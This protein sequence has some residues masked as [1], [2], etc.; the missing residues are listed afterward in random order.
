MT[1]LPSTKVEVLTGRSSGA[2]VLVKPGALSFM[3]WTSPLLSGFDGLAAKMGTGSDGLPEIGALGVTA[4]G[5]AA[6][7]AAGLDA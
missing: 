1:I 4:G 7:L 3:G 2:S 6:G 5:T